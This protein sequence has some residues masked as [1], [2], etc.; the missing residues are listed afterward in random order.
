ME[1]MVK[2]IAIT[3]MNSANHYWD[4]KGVNQDL[5]T[6]LTDSLMP[7]EG[8]G[9]TIHAEL[10]RAANRLGYEYCNNG[11]C[12]AL[13]VVLEWDEDYEDEIET[14]R[15]IDNYY[16]RMLDLLEDTFCN[17]VNTLGSEFKEAVETVREIQH[18]ILTEDSDISSR[19]FSDRNMS[20]YDRLIDFVLL[21]VQNTENCPFDYEF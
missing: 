3:E 19:Y 1:T 10:V 15:Y 17:A 11:N 9:K 14:D 7:A 21:Y 2:N 5:F 8:E 18:F 20:L 4:G 16:Q 6:E 12:N 13:E